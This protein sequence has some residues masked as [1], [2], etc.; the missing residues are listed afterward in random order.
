MRTDIICL[1][2]YI[3]KLTIVWAPNKNCHL[4]DSFGDLWH[5]Q[6]RQRLE[7]GCRKPMLGATNFTKRLST[8]SVEATQCRWM[9]VNIGEVRPGWR[10]R[11]RRRAPF[12]FEL[13]PFSFF[14]S[15][16]AG[17][18]IWVACVVTNLLYCRFGHQRGMLLVSWQFQETYGL[19][20]QDSGWRKDVSRCLKVGP[21]D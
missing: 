3:Y 7:N 2:G 18:C 6:L 20:S 11:R 5:N 17:V 9:H 16:C 13:L 10:R 21:V 8:K 1:C 15:F 19:T 4:I 12:W 14:F